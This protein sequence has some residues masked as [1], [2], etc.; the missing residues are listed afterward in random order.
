M[1]ALT[2]SVLANNYRAYKSDFLLFDLLS[3]TL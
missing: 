1:L 2:S 3:D